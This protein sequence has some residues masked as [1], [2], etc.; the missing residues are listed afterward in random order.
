MASQLRASEIIKKDLTYKL[1]EE[2][3]IKDVMQRDLKLLRQENTAFIEEMKE[4]RKTQRKLQEL[5]H[6][7]TILN[8]NIL[9]ID[10][11][12]LVPYGIC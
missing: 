8:G 5:Q 4:F 2:K 12:Q 10:K 9:F 3:N 1:S 6:I 11:C 7:E